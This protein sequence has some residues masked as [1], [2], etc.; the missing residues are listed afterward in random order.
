MLIPYVSL[1]HED[2]DFSVSVSIDITLYTQVQID[3]H[4]SHGSQTISAMKEWF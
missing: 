4:D 3:R 1:S 2:V